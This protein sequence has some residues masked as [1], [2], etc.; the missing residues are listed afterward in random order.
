MD[1]QDKPYDGLKT[2]YGI[3]GI[4][5]PDHLRRTVDGTPG[6]VLVI[7]MVE[8]ESFHEQMTAVAATLKQFETL[9][10]VAVTGEEFMACMARH[11][12]IKGTPTFLLFMAGK[13]KDRLLGLADEK[14]LSAFL[15]RNLAGGAVTDCP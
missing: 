1:E 15:E 6:P 10:A 12:H 5:N 8:N 13:I 3:A 14:T 7:L 11:F 4:S 9:P 2:R